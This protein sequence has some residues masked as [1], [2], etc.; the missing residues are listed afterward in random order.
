MEQIAADE[1]ELAIQGVVEAAMRDNLAPLVV[2]PDVL[3]EA[4]H[5]SRQMFP[6]PLCNPKN[7]P[8]QFSPLCERTTV[9]NIKLAQ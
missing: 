9:Q 4:A 7:L 5:F 6:R 3:P 2:E 1:W 8:L